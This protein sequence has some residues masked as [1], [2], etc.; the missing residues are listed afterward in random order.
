ME[1]EKFT[2]GFKGER[3]MLERGGGAR[4]LPPYL[5][6]TSETLGDTGRKTRPPV[7]G[8]TNSIRPSWMLSSLTFSSEI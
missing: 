2:D 6:S 3:E 1:E 7:F 5:D 8:C 4:A